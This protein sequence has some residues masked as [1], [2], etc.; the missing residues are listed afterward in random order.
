MDARIRDIVSFW[1]KRQD[2]C[3][4]SVV[5]AEA[6]ERCWRCSRRMRLQFCHITPRSRGG[7]DEPENIV[8]LCQ[9]CHREAPNVE[10]P[11]FMWFWLR[12]YAV[13]CYD[14]DWIDRGFE[15]F[16]KLF[17]RK[18]LADVDPN[19]P[20]EKFRELLKKYI[21]KTVVHFGEGRPNP[22]TVAWLLAQVERQVVQTRIPSDP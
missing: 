6:H 1:A 20:L 2:E 8:L 14:T 16:E 13:T 22:S 12:A 19:F 7:S 21:Q 10:D 11:S 4:L 15:E 18:P 3:G 5:W 9:R 17:K